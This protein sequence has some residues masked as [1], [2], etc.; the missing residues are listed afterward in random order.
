MRTANHLIRR[1]T[2][3]G[4]LVFLLPA[5]AHAERWRELTPAQRE[6]LAPLSRTWDSLERSEQKSFIGVANG[7]AK[8]PPTSKSVCAN[9]SRP[10][11]R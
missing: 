11:R 1:I 5:V 3:L 6:L 7:Y 10:G 9:R 4:S 2:L 8:L